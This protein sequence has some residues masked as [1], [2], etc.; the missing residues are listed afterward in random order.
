MK[1]DELDTF[2]LYL[3]IKMHFTTR[4]DFFL[5]KGK[6]KSKA[7]SYEVL[8]RK[9]YRGAIYKLS[10]VYDAKQLRDYFIANMLV[11]EGSHIFDVDSEGKRIYNDFI[12]RKDSRVYTYKQDINRVCIELEKLGKTD[13]WQ[14]LEV[15]NNRHPLLFRMFV[16][17]YISPETMCI[18]SKF[19]DYLNTWDLT[20]QDQM[21]YPVVAM[22]IRKLS[23]FIMIKDTTPF[24]EYIGVATEEILST[25]FKS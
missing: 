6:V 3:A 10:K 15:G 23:P 16:G 21:L 19:N 5:Y 11:N 8:L 25:N 12:R 14:C 24:S 4:Y 13:F 17:N 20:V 2:Q 18:L 9:N 7:C 22:Q 1:L